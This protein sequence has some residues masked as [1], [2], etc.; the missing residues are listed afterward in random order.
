MKKTLSITLSL[1]LMAG[2]FTPLANA[3]QGPEPPKSDKQFAINGAGATFP[4]P[5]IDTWRVE[6]N[7]LY[8]NVNLNYQSIGSG[9]GVQQHTAKTVNFGASDAPL[10][11]AERELVPGTM[12]IPEAIGSVVLAYYIP[13]VPQSGLKLTGAMVAD[14]YLGK[15]KKWNDPILQEANPDLKLPDR[16]ILVTRRSDGSGTTYVFTDY[17]SKVSPEWDEKVGKGKSVAWPTGVGAAGNEGVAWATRN[18]KY[19]IGY[20]E[21]AYAKSNEMTIAY[22]QNG[23]KTKFVEPTFDTVFEGAKAY[24]IEKIPKPEADWSQVSMVLS[25]GENSYPIVSFTYL[26]VYEDINQAVSNKDAAKTLV[27]ILHWM[28]TDGQKFSKPLGYVPLPE[29]IQE[30]DKQG[31]ARIKFNGEQL[32]NYGSIKTDTTKS[33]TAKTDVKKTDTKK[34][35]KKDTKKSDKKSEKKDTK[36]KIKKTIKKPTTSKTAT[37][38]TTGSK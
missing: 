29:A 24:P 23:D 9:G 27:H 1:I 34:S 38:K 28:V 4:F 22:L 15:I 20:V 37:S 3:A 21:L 25:P 31:I 33:D 2:V 10:T 16:P 35:E 36:K 17:L 8:S 30:L 18:T 14:I 7:K 5:L 26:L 19:A 6:Y 11:P 13:E 12:H 32:W